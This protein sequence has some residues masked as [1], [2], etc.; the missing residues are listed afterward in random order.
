[1]FQAGGESST[2]KRAKI[3]INDP[4]VDQQAPSKGFPG[5]PTQLLSL[6]FLPERETRKCISVSAL[7]VQV[8]CRTEEE[9]CG[10]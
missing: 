6:T 3:K 9:E 5:T 7:L 8:F 2:G 10:Y 4:S 1:M